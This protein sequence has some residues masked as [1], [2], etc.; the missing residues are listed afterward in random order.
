MTTGLTIGFAAPEQGGVRSD[1]VVADGARQFSLLATESGYL[2]PDVTLEPDGYQGNLT[3]HLPAGLEVAD[4]DGAP[5][6]AALA[7]AL[8]AVW[9]PAD[10]SRLTVTGRRVLVS[11]A[12]LPPEV[13]HPGPW[14]P[15]DPPGDPVVIVVTWKVGYSGALSPGAAHAAVQ[16]TFLPPG[17]GRTASPDAEPPLLVLR[18]SRA[19]GHRA[20]GEQGRV[21]AVDFGTTASTA[22][23]VDTS[24][25]SDRPVDATQQRTLGRELAALTA[26]PS[27]A[28]ESWRRALEGLRAEHLELDRQQHRTLTGAEALGRLD[29]L[30]VATAVLLHVEAIRA[31]AVGD[32]QLQA[33]LADRLHRLV[34]A[35]VATPPLDIHSLRPVPYPDGHGGETFAPATAIRRAAEPFDRPGVS[36]Y[37]DAGWELCAEDAGGVTGLKRVFFEHR[38]AGPRDGLPA[39]LHLIQHLLRLL[40]E[41]AERHV[42]DGEGGEPPRMG[43]ALLTYPTSALPQ[44]REKLGRLVQEGLSIDTVDLRVDEGLAAGLY[45]LMRDLTANL[46]QGLESLRASSRPVPGRTDQWQRI[47]LVV[48]VGGGTSDIAL[49]EMTL[50]DDTGLADQASAFVAG[51]HYKL[52]PRILG[53]IGHG[54]L[55]GDLLTL[56]VLYWIKA[57]LADELGPGRPLQGPGGKPLSAQVAEQ[58]GEYR[59]EL[60]S[61]GVRAE[62]QRVLPTDWYGMDA[63]EEADEVAVRRD[64]FNRLWRTAEQAKRVL[65]QEDQPYLIDPAD[66]IE[67]TEGGGVLLEHPSAPVELPVAEFR[68]LVQPVLE[69]AATMAASLVADA[70][71][72]MTPG[73][74][75]AE[76]VLDQVV[77]SGRTS[78]MKGVRRALES[79][80]AARLLATQGDGT[81]RTAVWNPSRIHTETGYLAKQATSIGAAWLHNMRGF[82]GHAA[83]L[84]GDGTAGSEAQASELAVETK[85]LFAC[86]P[87]DFDLLGQSRQAFSLFRSGTPYEEL[88]ADGR[89]GLRSNWR[90]VVR[91]I[92]VQR[93]RAGSDAIQWGHLDIERIPDYKRYATPSVWDFEGTPEIRFQAEVDNRLRL[94]VLLCHGDPQYHVGSADAGSDESGLDLHGA[95]GG[96]LAFDHYLGRLSVPGAVCISP[97]RPDGRT[98]PL[99]EVFPAHP[100]GGE[101]RDYLGLLFHTSA[102]PDPQIAPVPG[103]IARL[104][105][106]AGPATHL[107]VHLRP[108]QG[109]PVRLGRLA[110]PPAN[111]DAA[112]DDLRFTLDAHG[113]LRVHRG[114]VP[115]P[116]AGSFAHIEQRPGWVYRAEM[117]P[118]KREFNSYWDPTS[119]RH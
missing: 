103:R 90:R 52:S 71:A 49:L 105:S 60:V 40:V 68:M 58:A 85:G 119:R 93:P 10:A 80:L 36:W 53:T 116:E 43:T 91:R 7:A 21:V 98:G 20:R 32:E 111:G 65:G 23:V 110:V 5:C 109:E 106:P 115:Y 77:L 87:C 8:R 34:T 28:P 39:P 88:T 1:A 2:L 54:Q 82:Q 59:K 33:W 78:A 51:R 104:R 86:L 22:T 113:W 96:A 61:P 99:T 26:P 95:A 69:Q 24:V 57:R 107:D 12:S 102:R 101:P 70:F 89:L 63:P 19:R 108:A 100:E 47:M 79:K 72:R 9:A 94:F 16:L 67:L 83:G 38:F 3:A 56:H 4:E 74:G 114:Q 11:G 27:D 118:G 37:D 6:P 42:D 81:R 35:T 92:V 13:V 50:T 46:E 84:H 45:F 48:D 41:G 62:L 17:V 29:E 30:D 117:E 97:A 31:G 75:R 73:D 76:P 55:G 66:I 14:D 25:I 15:S 44:D 64:R 112:A 18:D